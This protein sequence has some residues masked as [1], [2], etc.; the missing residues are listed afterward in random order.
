MSS[1]VFAS[2]Q[3]D[4][5]SVDRID[6][7]PR[8]LAVP[9]RLRRFCA[10]TLVASLLAALTLATALAPVTSA[11]ARRGRRS[12]GSR[13]Q[14]C[15]NAQLRIRSAYRRIQL[16][17]AVLCLIN[18]QRTQRGLPELHANALL[19]RSAQGWTDVMVAHR[20]FSHGADFAARISAVGY[21]W[22]SVGEN[23]ATGLATPAS[24][25]RAWMASTGHCQNILDPVYHDVGT[26]VSDGPTVASDGTWTQ[27][28][29][30]LM[31]HSDP[32][33]DWGPA[34]GCPY[35]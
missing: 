29:G 30:L 1:V 32:S 3:L 26:G 4:Q 18:Q 34:T 8:R 25:V 28:F 31:G 35:G 23:I 14:A 10:T 22:S 33:H 11:Q 5:L 6:A 16:Q 7:I 20:L 2:P 24:V 21:H 15:P 17:R 19:D 9:T 13:T 12:G 27:D